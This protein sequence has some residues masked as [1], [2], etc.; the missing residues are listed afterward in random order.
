ME[1]QKQSEKKNKQ[2]RAQNELFTLTAGATV[3]VEGG[4]L[5]G[6]GRGS[7]TG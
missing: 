7:V 4:S 3:G 6:V 2:K 5:E 1:K